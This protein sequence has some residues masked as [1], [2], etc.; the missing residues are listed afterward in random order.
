MS[1][2]LSGEIT[3]IATAVLALFAIVTAIYAIRA[4]RTQSDELAEQR[5]INQK[6]TEVLELQAT[7]LRESLNERKHEAAGRRRAQAEA[8]FIGAMSDRDGNSVPS[9][10][11]TSS[12]PVYDAC[13]WH[14]GLD[15]ENFPDDIGA[16][17]PGQNITG[18]AGYGRSYRRDT[19][20]A[21][22][23]VV[24]IFRDAA[25]TTWMRT[26]DGILTEHP[27]GE[28]DNA[29]RA[30][31]DALAGGQENPQPLPRRRRR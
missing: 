2:D 14:L 3:A 15:E 10:V 16:V 5:A 13:F 12:R 4:F 24:L 21:D 25:G 23:E 22:M 9:V 18:A 6:Q 7:E 19:N 17:L 28:L 27:P 11:N 31:L 20:P 26:R 8:I 1:V 30:A 29:A